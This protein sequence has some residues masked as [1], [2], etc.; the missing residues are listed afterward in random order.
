M[1]RMQRL[2]HTND[3]GAGADKPPADFSDWIFMKLDELADILAVAPGQSGARE[4]VDVTADLRQAR[5]GSVFVAG[6]RNQGGWC[7][8]APR[9]A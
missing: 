2:P 9:S 8:L 4:I 3:P 7:N 1:K 6:I 5:P